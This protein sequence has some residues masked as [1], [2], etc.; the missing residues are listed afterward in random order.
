MASPGSAPG[1]ARGRPAGSPGR[2]KTRGRSSW[3]DTASL[4]HWPARSPR[5]ARRLPCRRRHSGGPVRRPPTGVPRRCRGARRRRRQPVGPRWTR[6]RNTPASP[7]RPGSAD[8]PPRAAQR[9]T[10]SSP[11]WRGWG[12]L[13]LTGQS[14]GGRPAERNKLFPRRRKKRSGETKR[15]GGTRPPPWRRDSPSTAPGDERRQAWGD[16]DGKPKTREESQ[17]PMRE[18]VVLPVDSH[19][20]RSTSGKPHVRSFWIMGF[21][22]RLPHWESERLVQRPRLRA[23]WQTAPSHRPLLGV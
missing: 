14:C 20:S 19:V 18:R 10:R 11:R 7:G 2:Q 21:L 23:G 17:Q 1:R 22:R 15:H 16:E 4:C 6:G 13:T 12:W 5:A 3:A 8:R 9:Q